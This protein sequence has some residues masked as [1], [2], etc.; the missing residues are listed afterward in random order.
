MDKHRIDFLTKLVSPSIVLVLI[1]TIRASQ[2]YLLG[3]REALFF[4]LLR[5]MRCEPPCGLLVIDSAVTDNNPLDT[6]FPMTRKAA[7]AHGSRIRHKPLNDHRPA[8]SSTAATILWGRSVHVAGS[9]GVTS[10]SNASPPS[11]PV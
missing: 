4:D 1:N 3:S 2:L 7:E 6:T 9:L 5:R 10:E 11:L 8:S